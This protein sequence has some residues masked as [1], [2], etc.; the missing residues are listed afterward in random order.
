MKI[1]NRLVQH[2]G[3]FY[4]VACCPQ[5][6]WKQSLP[7]HWTAETGAVISG[8]AL[9]D[10]RFTDDIAPLTEDTIGLQNSH[11]KVITESIEDG[12]YVVKMETQ[13]LGKG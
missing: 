11:E 1:Y 13:Y 9:G 2:I 5:C 10:L 6:Y 8:N 12:I 3:E 4:R 7:W